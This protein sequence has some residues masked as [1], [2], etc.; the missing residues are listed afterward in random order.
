MLFSPVQ[1]FCKTIKLK[2]S[3]LLKIHNYKYVLFMGKAQSLIKLAN[4][5][6]GVSQRFF[7]DFKPKPNMM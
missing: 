6:M 7:G 3:N 2:L 5:L 1:S 4:Q